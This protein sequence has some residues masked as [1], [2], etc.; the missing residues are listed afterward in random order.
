[1]DADFSDSKTPKICVLFRVIRGK[2]LR[3]LTTIA[4]LDLDPAAAGFGA[5]VTGHSHKPQVTSKNGAIYINPGIAGPGF[6]GASKFEIPLL[7][8]VSRR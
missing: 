8:A 5:V 1:M 6:P 4:D 2:S 3:R 7:R